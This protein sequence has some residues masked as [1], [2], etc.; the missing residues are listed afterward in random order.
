MLAHASLLLL[1]LLGASVSATESSLPPVDTLFGCPLLDRV[2]AF[3]SPR[4]WKR[5]ALSD[6]G[7]S[8][9]VPKGWTMQATG[10][11]RVLLEVASRRLHLNVKKT[12]FVEASQLHRVRDSL[13]GRELGF[14]HVNKRCE[15]E[16]SKRIGQITGLKV[17]VG[18]YGRSLAKRRRNFAAFFVVDERVVSV[19][20]TL[21]WRRRDQGPS[22]P[23]VRQVLASVRRLTP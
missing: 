4:T 22:L 8:I 14:S 9:S 2:S 11:G 16:L 3:E 10:P 23:L 15:H 19:V 18:V 6:V 5:V 21:R 20:L 17:T 1:G 13:E 7:I 12:R